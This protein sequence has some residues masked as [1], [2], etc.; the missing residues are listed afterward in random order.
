MV[1]ARGRYSKA[2]ELP[3][4]QAEQGSV[5]TTAQHSSMMVMGSFEVILPAEEHLVLTPNQPEIPGG[6]G[7]PPLPKPI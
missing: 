7:P 5:L 4:C 2:E 6:A 1:M 3:D